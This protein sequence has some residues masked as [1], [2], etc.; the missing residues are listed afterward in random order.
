MPELLLILYLLI[1]FSSLENLLPSPK[2]FFR[3]TTNEINE[4]LPKLH[5]LFPDF[6]SRIRALSQLRL[7][8]PYELKAVGE[9]FGFEP[10]PIFRIDKT[11]CTAFVLTNIALASARSYQLAESLMTYLNYYQ[12]PDG[13]NPVTYKNRIHFTSDRLLTSEYFELI[14]TTLAQPQQLD[15]AH[16]VLNRQSNGSHFLPIDWEKGI[17]L[18]FIRKQFITPELLK[19]LPAVCG[20]GI[21]QQELFKKGIA[22]AH[23]GFLFDGKDFIH[24]SIDAGKVKREDFLRYCRKKKKGSLMP[25]CDGIVLYLMREVKLK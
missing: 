25:V 17:E 11:N 21:I 3:L 1:T 22:I 10:K 6:Q 4:L 5:N 15:T 9:G 16:L 7:G 18:P 12:V 19:K 2:K 20:V 14:T 24:A 13:K 23:E 8:T